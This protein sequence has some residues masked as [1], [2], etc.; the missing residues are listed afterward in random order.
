[1]S[2]LKGEAAGGAQNDV[3][4][5]R[6]SP[7]E[8]GSSVALGLTLRA[9]RASSPHEYNRDN[10]EDPQCRA[11]GRDAGRKIGWPDGAGAR[12]VPGRSGLD[13]MRSWP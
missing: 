2:K 11:L 12:P 5:P 10:L 7:P 8:R 6:P 1:M 13:G 4:P 9:R 3:R